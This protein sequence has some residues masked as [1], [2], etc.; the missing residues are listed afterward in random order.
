ML[1]VFCDVPKLLAL[2][3]SSVLRELVEGG[4]TVLRVLETVFFIANNKNV[5][6]VD[7]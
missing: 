6:R 5:E 4:S 2:N 1:K 3:D 7:G